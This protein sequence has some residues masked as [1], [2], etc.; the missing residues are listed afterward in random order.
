MNRR[1]PRLG[2]T[3]SM[4]Q[5]PTETL[6]ALFGPHMHDS[7]QDVLALLRKLEWRGDNVNHHGY[8]GFCPSCGNDHATG[9]RTDCEL[10]KLLNGPA[11]RLVG[12]MVDKIMRLERELAEVKRQNA[13]LQTYN[14]EQ[15]ERR[16]K[17]EDELKSCEVC[18]DAN[19]REVSKLAGEVADLYKEKR[20]LRGELRK[21]GLEYEQQAEDLE[22]VL[23]WAK[24]IH[25]LA[26]HGLVL[27]AGSLGIYTSPVYPDPASL[28][29]ELYRHMAQAGAARVALHP[30]TRA[31]KKAKSS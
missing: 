31:A 14:N 12:H 4:D 29:H 2:R 16:R 1:K 21:R 6:E 18:L 10:N 26:R 15:M 27:L 9:H 20:E 3:P 19:R 23:T 22:L 24:D 5:K 30:L 25:D 7:S 28:Y 11:P 17:A 13:E 8:R